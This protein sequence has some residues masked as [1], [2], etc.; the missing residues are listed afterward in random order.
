[1]WTSIS[2]FAPAMRENTKSEE[3]ID[4]DIQSSMNGGLLL[5]RRYEVVQY[6]MEFSPPFFLSPRL[7]IIT[8]LI[9][10]KDEYWD[11]DMV[12]GIAK[13]IIR[14]NGAESRLGREG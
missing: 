4:T 8:P 11:I 10:Y 9:L 6:S 3:L 2:I 12:V 7:T 13:R 1:M 5:P 14:R